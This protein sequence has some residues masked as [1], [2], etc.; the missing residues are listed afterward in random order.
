[1]L[2]M[3]YSLGKAFKYGRRLMSTIE[4]HQQYRTYLKSEFE[5]RLGK[6]K[7]YSLRAYARDLMLS[8]Q[9]LS[10]ILSGKKHISVST[11]VQISE[12]LNHSVIE[13]SMFLD[14]ILLSSVDH[15]LLKR[16]IDYREKLYSLNSND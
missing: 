12:K 14:L 6:N 9:F 8:P 15:P 2:V 3:D 7:K 10:H 5:S 11:A 4:V 16:I 1:M 13:A